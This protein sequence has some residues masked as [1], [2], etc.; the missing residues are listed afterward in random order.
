LFHGGA[1]Q[2]AS[3]GQKKAASEEAAF[4]FL[5]IRFKRMLA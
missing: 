1:V 3:R 2:T 5:A 4:S